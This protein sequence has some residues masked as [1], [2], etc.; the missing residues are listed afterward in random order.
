LLDKFLE[1]LS[2]EKEKPKARKKKIIRQPY[3]E[4][5]DC[6]SIKLENNFF[7]GL[8]VLEE[9][10]DTELGLN[11]IVATNIYKNSK[12]T[13]ADFENAEALFSKF[14]NSSNRFNIGWC[15]K[16]SF[17]KITEEIEII[18]K[19]KV[20][21]NYSEND[22]NSGFYYNGT[23]GKFRLDIETQLKSRKENIKPNDK[24][25]IKNLTKKNKWK[26]W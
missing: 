3:F 2:T 23:L 22:Y 9:V 21:I 26:F 4:K 24:N 7:G 14:P 13:I 5:G 11:L 19:I 18:G 1:T 8:I 17:R 6:I 16:I 15:Y 10:R 25:S 12:P 20:E